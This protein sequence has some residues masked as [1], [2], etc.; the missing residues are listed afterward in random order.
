MTQAGGYGGNKSSRTSGNLAV[1]EFG[2]K[3]TPTIKEVG[4]KKE[5]KKERK[6]V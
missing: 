6:K 4:K 1:V 5:R 2:Q 3:F